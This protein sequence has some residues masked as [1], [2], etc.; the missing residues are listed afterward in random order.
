[1]IDT[2]K[3]ICALQPAYSSQNTSPMKERGILIRQTLPQELRALHDEFAAALGPFGADLSFEGRDGTGLKTSSPW[4]RIFARSMSPSAREGFYVVLHFAADGSA[5]FITVGCGS[6]IWANGDLHPIEGS[7]LDR[8]TRW[9]RSI[10]AEQFG[11]LAPFDQSIS[12]GAASDLSR[13][14]ERATALSRRVSV[15]EMDDQSIETFL[16]QAVERLRA[17][18]EAQ[19][20][21][22]DIS[23]AAA[24]ELAVER[25]AAPSA[26]RFTGQGFGLTADERR[27]VELHAM[28]LAT[29]ALK[30]EGFS[31]A[32][33]STTSSFDLLASNAS[34]QLKIEVKGTT[35]DS[36]EA[37][38]LT[39]R[40]LLLHREE[41]G[42]TGL[43]VVSS[44]RLD[45]SATSPIAS[46][47][48]VEVQ[49]RWD[50]DS[51][52]AIPLAFRLTRR[53]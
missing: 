13:S 32:D 8:R 49:L 37:I 10:V 25:L 18:Y 47:G 3:R 27:V 34:E 28:E 43:I 14:F 44:I 15:E 30:K 11:T 41:K 42:K 51:W 23:S 20:A 24:I 39:Q 26:T 50:V 19:H 6:T 40:E 33:V 46:G 4:T 48:K 2:L 9:A 45:R 17:I 5:V 52:D 35:N 31:V 53:V 29:I 16:V 22:R 21:E 12:L 7:V 1:M 36:G 38:L